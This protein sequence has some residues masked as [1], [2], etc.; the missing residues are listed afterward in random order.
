MLST[1]AALCLALWS[2]PPAESA[3]AIETLAAKALAEVPGQHAYVF[4]EIRD[5]VAIPLHGLHAEER[6]AVGSSFKLYILGRLI[7]DVNAGRRKLSDTTLL[8]ADQHGPPHSEM[9]DW[10]VG[11][12]VTAS[13]LA[14]KMISISDNTATDHL[15]FLLGREAVEQQLPIMG[16]TKPSVNLPLLSTRE[17]TCLRDKALGMPGKAYLK[18][19]E[20]GRRAFLKKEFSGVPDYDALDFDTA[21]YDVAEWYASPVEMAHA[22]AWIHQHTAEDLP[23]ALVRSILTVDGKLPLDRKIWPFVGFK[24]GSEDQ[25]LAG[26]WLLQHRTGRWFTYHVY[27]NN[28]SGSVKPELALGPM[29]AILAAI[30]ATLK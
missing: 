22:L 23:A 18:L 8:R 11:L 1:S 4:T 9:A 16:H 26:N 14:L 24:G 13:T 3:A 30:E 5:H 19:D 2:A 21:A 7:A 12:P 10:P 17:M 15:L 6:F 25:L 28:P 20:A 29:L 27:L